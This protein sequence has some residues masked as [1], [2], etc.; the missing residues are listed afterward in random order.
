MPKVQAGRRDVSVGKMG[1]RVAVT[2]MTIEHR[3]ASS[4][5]H[6]LCARRSVAARVRLRRLVW[7]RELGRPR[8]RRRLLRR[9]RPDER[10]SCPR[11]PGHFVLQLR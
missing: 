1:N 4:R 11:C 8:L 9:R 7:C 2:R 5:W 10:L 3:P 6:A